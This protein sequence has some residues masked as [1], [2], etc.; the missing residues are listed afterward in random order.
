MTKYERSRLETLD[1]A[2]RSESV[3]T[4]S[5]HC[6]TRSRPT[7]S[8]KRCANDL[9]AVSVGDSLND[10]TACDSICVGICSTHRR[11]HRRRKASEQSSTHDVVR[12]QWR[13]ANR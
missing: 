12:R 2:L 13:F 9:G 5:P 8:Q 3:R 6:D 4:H 1:T 7:G 10:T 11:R